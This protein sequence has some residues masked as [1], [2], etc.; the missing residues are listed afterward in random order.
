LTGAV[1]SQR[2]TEA[3]KGFL[4][5]DGN[6]ATECKGIRELDSET[7]RSSWDESRA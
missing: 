6:R 4:S 2:V 5:A 7:N 1:A 3:S